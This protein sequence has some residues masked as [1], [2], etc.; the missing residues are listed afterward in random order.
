MVASLGW[1]KSVWIDTGMQLTGKF[2]TVAGVLQHATPARDG[3]QDVHDGDHGAQEG[4][5]Q[6]VRH[7]V[8][9]VNDAAPGVRQG[10]AG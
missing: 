6:H 10:P 3:S 1:E 5:A 2:R 8:L 7:V 9:V 4:A